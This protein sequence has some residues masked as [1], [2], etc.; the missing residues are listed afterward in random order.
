MGPVDHNET[1]LLCPTWQTREMDED[2]SLRVTDWQN[3]FAGQDGRIPSA[4]WRRSGKLL[5]LAD[6]AVDA[7]VAAGRARAREAAREM[8][9]QTVLL[10]AVEVPGR[11]VD[12]ARTVDQLRTGTHHNVALSIVPMA[13][14]G[15]FENINRAIAGHDLTKFHWLLV[16]DDDILLPKDF[17]DLLIYFSYTYSF[18]LAQPAHRFL[19]YASYAVTERHYGSLARRTGFVEIGP[20][21]LFHKDTFEI[22]TPFPSLRWSWGLDLLWSYVARQYDWRVGVIDAVPICH[23]RPIAESYDATEALDEAVAF[24]A[25]RGISMTRAEVFGLNQK[26]A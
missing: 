3:F 20:V 4:H 23:L 7:R 15:K 2:A 6:A 14:V 5:R 1:F 12:L 25:L 8:P 10:A 9:T 13:P 24:L 11:E 16:V 17:L 18:K 21:S 26:V 19:S 22:L